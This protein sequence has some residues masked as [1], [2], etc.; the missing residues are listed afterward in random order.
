MKDNSYPTIT[1]YLSHM[2]NYETFKQICKDIDKLVNN[3]ISIECVG[4]KFKFI[5]NKKSNLSNLGTCD[6]KPETNHIQI[7][8]YFDFE[9]SVD[10]N[11]FKL[12]DK[13]IQDE[14]VHELQSYKLVYKTNEENI[15]S[16]GQV[17]FIL[18]FSQTYKNRPSTFPRDSC[19]MLD[20]LIPVPIKKS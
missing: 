9:S 17:P 3:G 15:S 8:G 20:V 13:E 12:L 5:A 1:H 11:L 6:L 14:L 19:Y 7:F 4:I 18:S 16:F 2:I 10:R